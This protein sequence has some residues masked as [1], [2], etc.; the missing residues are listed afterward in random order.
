MSKFVGFD[1]FA[2]GGMDDDE[3]KFESL[4]DLED[5]DEES[6]EF[7][8]FIT[9]KTTDGYSAQDVEDAIAQAIQDSAPSE[10]D[11]ASVSVSFRED[12][13]EELEA[14]EGD[15]TMLWIGEAF[16]NISLPDSSDT[17]KEVVDNSLMGVD[18]QDEDGVCHDITLSLED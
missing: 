7:K 6:V 1:S 14:L 13:A 9:T 10:L 18:V 15:L 5:G 4:H 16:I 3:V 11:I 17:T 12:E 8:V 2:D